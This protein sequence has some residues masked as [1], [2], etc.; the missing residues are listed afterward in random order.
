[1]SRCEF[2]E[3]AIQGNGVFAVEP[4]PAGQKLFETHSGL[5]DEREWANL[6]PNCLYN[7]SYTPNCKS[8]TGEKFKYLVTLRNIEAGEEL[9]SDY[10]KD[11]DLEQPQDDWV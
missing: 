6:V 10:T 11:P 7:H 4:L 9:T 8:V 1:M 2:R 3:S 5:P